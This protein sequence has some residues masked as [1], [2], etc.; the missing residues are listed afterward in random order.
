[1]FVSQPGAMAKKMIP[2]MN[3]NIDLGMGYLLLFSQ[4]PVCRRPAADSHMICNIL[5]GLRWPVDHTGP[6]NRMI[7]SPIR[8]GL[9]SDDTGVFHRADCNQRVMGRNC[10]CQRNVDGTCFPVHPLE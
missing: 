2:L 4:T 6:R 7:N 1:M 9:E 8:P 5:Q 3:F 10:P